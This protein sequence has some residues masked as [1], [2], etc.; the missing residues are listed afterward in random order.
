MEDSHL[1]SE[2][3]AKRLFYGEDPQTLIVEYKDSLTA[4]NAQKKASIEGKG[5]LNNQISALL[6]DYLENNGIR[7]HYIQIID[8]NHQLVKKTKIV[9]LEVVVRNITTGS[10][11]KRLGVPEGKRLDP[12]L[13]EFY[14]K[15]D[16]LGDPIVTE[17]QAS[18]FGWA[19]RDEIE[20]MKSLALKVNDLLRV[21]FEKRNVVLVD[22][23]LEFGRTEE[24]EL[25]VADEISPD[26]CRFWDTS[27]GNSLDKDRF[28]KDLGNVLEA[29]E[30][31]RRRICAG[32]RK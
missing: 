14:L 8:K 27:S 25:V 24:G 26:T 6:F 17:D 12:G 7:T 28:R 4:Y 11:C 5:T 15:N 23:K 32:E 2:G 10:I 29:Y 9:P 22:F 20:E 21:F 16:E 31:I 30:E 3:K 1:I 19:T 13:V 18:T